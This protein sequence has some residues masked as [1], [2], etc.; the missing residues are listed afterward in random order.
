MNHKAKLS[1]LLSG[2]MLIVSAIYVSCNTNVGDGDDPATIED[3]FFEN[4]ARQLTW[5]APGDDGDSGRARI[6]D[7]RFFE[8]IEVAELLN[9]SLVDFNTM[10]PTFDAAI[11]E[12]VRDN[13]EDA[14]QIQDESQPD[15]ARTPENFVVNRLDTEGTKR[16][17][18]VLTARDEVGNSSSPSNV[19]EVQTPLVSAEFRNSAGGSCFG[20]AVGGGDFDGDRLDDIVIGDPCL[21]TVYIF[22]GRNDL[23]T[24]S[25]DGDGIFDV[26]SAD[27]ADITIIGEAGD[28][29]GSAVAGVGNIG[30][31][32]ADDLAIGATDFNGGTGRVFIIFGSSALAE[33]IDFTSGDLPDHLITGESMGDSF[34]A[35]ITGTTG[36]EGGVGTRLLI[37]APDANSGRGKAY[38]FRGGDIEENTPASDAQAIFLGETAG[39]M[40][41]FALSRGGD[42]DDDSFSEFAVGAP[43]AGK[44]YVFFGQGNVNGK[45]LSLDTSGVVV[46]SGGANEFGTSI[47]GG[48]DINEDGEGTPDLLIGAPGS[49]SDRGSVFLYSGED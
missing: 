3:L 1:L 26:G 11:E 34:G 45:D 32:S 5:T 31:G 8:D 42:F 38:L 2:L 6:Y 33:T 13:F 36:V 48:Q 23:V 10:H 44:V 12:A 7:L 27:T 20:E 35:S 14:T 9:L 18:F 49:N 30:G 21:G 41:G 19:V 40:F 15:E 24:G 47:A 29:F 43:G 22:F 46:I 17:F 39:D 28:R 16:F 37:G 4:L 25:E